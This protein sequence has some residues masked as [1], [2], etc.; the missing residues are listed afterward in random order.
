MTRDRMGPP[1]PFRSRVSFHNTTPSTGWRYAYATNGTDDIHAEPAR[2]MTAAMI[3]LSGLAIVGCVPQEKYA[4][5]KLDRDRLAEQLGNS[6]SEI[7]Q[8]KAQA[9]AYKSQLGAIMGAGNNRDAIIQNLTT[10]N[11]DLQ[12]QLDE[13]NGKYRDAVA[14][15]AKAGSGGG[16]TETALPAPLSSELSTFASENPDLVDFDPPAAS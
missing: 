12:R 2:V 5:L 13:L 6:Q 4:A 1:V 9:D 16:G 11:G 14:L 3:G 10:Q 7:E 15:T 8:A